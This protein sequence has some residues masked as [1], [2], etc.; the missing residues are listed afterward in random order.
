MATQP[1]SCGHMYFH[2]Q[3]RKSFQLGQKDASTARLLNSV[4]ADSLFNQNVMGSLSES[5]VTIDE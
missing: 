4:Y 5:V 1:I 3:L 2:L